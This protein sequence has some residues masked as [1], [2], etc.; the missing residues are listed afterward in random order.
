M[1][2]Y[3]EPADTAL[4]GVLGEWMVKYNIPGDLRILLTKLNIQ[5]IEDVVKLNTRELNDKLEL[6]S[7]KRI[8]SLQYG[9]QKKL[10]QEEEDQKQLLNKTIRKSEIKFDPKKL[11]EGKFGIVYSVLSL[12]SG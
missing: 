1:E 11:G 7:I 5:S 3:A 4:Q 12:L 8:E 9:I 10:E 2:E 6:V